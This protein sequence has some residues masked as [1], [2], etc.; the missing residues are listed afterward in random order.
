M[1]S[2]SQRYVGATHQEKDFSHCAQHGLNPNSNGGEGQFQV[3]D[4]KALDEHTEQAVS[5][6]LVLFLAENLD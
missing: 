1:V 4:E 3:F 5:A 2:N 6:D